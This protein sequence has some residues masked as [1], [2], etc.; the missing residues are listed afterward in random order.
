MCLLADILPGKVLL[1]AYAERPN[2][3]RGCNLRVILWNFWNEESTHYKKKKYPKC[4]KLKCY[5][6]NKVDRAALKTQMLAVHGQGRQGSL[7]KSQSSGTKSELQFGFKKK[8][9]RVSLQKDMLKL[10]SFPFLLPKS[11][12]PT[13]NTPPFTF[14]ECQVGTTGAWVGEVTDTVGQ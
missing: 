9:C 1:K 11:I 14:T 5:Q 13:P 3:F 8:K 12:S 7:S 10:P 6:S 4:Y 2:I